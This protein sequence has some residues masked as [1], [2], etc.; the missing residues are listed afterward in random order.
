M[1]DLGSGMVFMTSLSVRG[2]GGF[3]TLPSEGV[4]I[5]LVTVLLA[6]VGVKERNDDC[7]RE[8]VTVPELPPACTQ[9]AV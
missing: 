6:G 1:G 3:T 8:G 9:G 7:R 5:D 4:D 2:N